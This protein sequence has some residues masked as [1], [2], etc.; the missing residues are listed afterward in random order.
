MKRRVIAADFS[1]AVRAV[2]SVLL[3]GLLPAVFGAGRINDYLRGEQRL[4]FPRPLLASA[5]PPP[6]RL[7]RSGRQRTRNQSATADPSL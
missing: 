5:T 6:A 1:P 7:N 3:L 4:I 2:R